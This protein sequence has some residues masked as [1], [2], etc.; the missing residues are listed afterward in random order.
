MPTTQLPWLKPEDPFPPVTDALDDPNGL[1]CAG[2]D[3]SPARLLDAYRHGIFPWY[4]EG[5]PVLWWSPSPR[6]VLYPDRFKCSRSLL[7]VDRNAG[8]RVTCNQA[9]TDVIL[10]CGHVR[11]STWITPEMAAAYTRLHRTGWAH[12]VEV[13]LGDELVGGLYG[14]AMGRIFFGESMFSLV[15]DASKIALLHLCRALTAQG[16][17]MIDCQQET[18]HLLSL[19]AECISREDFQQTLHYAQTAS[20]VTIHL[21]S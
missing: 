7:K 20:P 11:T 6:C 19:G 8:F 13:W 10:A 1:L 17:H 9:F 14:L 5:E 15:N 18:E 3:L 4:G 21:L 2:A 12:S 16:F